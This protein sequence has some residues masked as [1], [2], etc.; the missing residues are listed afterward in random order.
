MLHILLVPTAAQ[1][2]SKDVSLHDSQLAAGE[3][4][5]GTTDDETD[6]FPTITATDTAFEENYR[7]KA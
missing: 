3:S 7:V 4:L 5:T 2:E 1:Q 6:Y